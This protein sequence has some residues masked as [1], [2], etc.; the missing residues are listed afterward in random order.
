MPEA[1]HV[2]RG[3]RIYRPGSA[4]PL[5]R[6]ERKPRPYRKCSTGSP[7]PRPTE[8]PRKEVTRKCR[9]VRLPR[10]ARHSTRRLSFLHPAR[11]V[12]PSKDVLAEPLVRPG[13]SHP[14]DFPAP[15]A[16]F[17]VPQA[18]PPGAG[19][20]LAPFPAGIGWRGRVGER[21][22]HWNGSSRLP[23]NGGFRRKG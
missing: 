12:F 7:A 2:L 8:S 20:R 22:S 15:V 21:T 17:G 4:P 14:H 11:C 16:D 13:G 18:G 5:P 6:L 9:A 23:P 3:I 10:R 19:A 1:R